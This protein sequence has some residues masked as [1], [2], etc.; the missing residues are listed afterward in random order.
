MFTF[1]KYLIEEAGEDKLKHLEH[2]EDHVINSGSAG[3]S[4][5][6]HSLNDVHSQL[7]GQKNETKMTVKYDG[8]P[9]VVFGTHPKT[10]KFFVGSKSV[11]NKDPKINYTNKDIE[12]NHGHAPGLVTKL[13]AALEHLP[14]V[15]PGTGIY[16]GDIMHTPEDL[17]KEGNRVAY[18]PNTITYHHPANSEHGKA[19]LKSK[20]GI[21]VHTK[22]EGN[23]FENMKAVHGAD[24]ELNKHP[25]VHAISV[26]HDVSKANYSLADQAEHKKHMASAVAEFKKASKETYAA[27]DKHQIPL[28]TYINSTVRS[29]ETP[30]TKGFIKHYSTA[31][32]KKV[33]SVKTDKSKDMYRGQMD[34]KL[35]E[36]KSNKAHFDTILNIHKHLQNSKNVLT[37]ALASHTE[38]GH[39]IGGVATKPEGFVVTR[40]G[41]PSK[42]VDRKEFSAANFANARG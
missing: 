29:G 17:K 41:R 42:F 32:Q 11:F 3:F 2:V 38:V 30:D 21:A 36:I 10:G 1:K 35:S 24:I 4:H 40:N 20:I 33:A 6:F 18:K 16:Q 12:K 19:A 25:D 5:A 27:V 23:D 26:Q 15:H 34:K 22:Y 7:L 28:K 13:K 14:K 39:E 31:L 37:N 8:S 9:S